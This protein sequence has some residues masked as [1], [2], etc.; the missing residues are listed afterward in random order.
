MGAD[1]K[2]RKGR[3]ALSNT[4]SRYEEYRRAAFDDGWADA[5]PDYVCPTT[6]LPDASK[7]IITFNKSP[8]IPFDRSINPY[9]GCEHGCVYCFARPSHTRLGLSAGLDF[10][11][12]LFFKENG[13]ELLRKELAHP[14][15]QAAELVLGANTD[16]Y[17]PVERKLGLTRRL[18]EVLAETKHPVSILTKSALVERDADILAEMAK[19]NLVRVFVS[20][21]TL[22]AKL[23]RALE[24]RA[25]SPARRLAILTSLTASGIP[26]GALIAPLIPVLTDP[27]LEQLLAAARTAGAL[28][29]DYVLLRLPSEIKTLFNEWLATH[30]PL[31]AAHVM[32]RVHDMRGGKA[33]DSEFGTRMTGTGLFAGIIAQ[34]FKLAHKKLQFPGM[35]ALNTSSSRWLKPRPCKGICSRKS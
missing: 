26:T 29:A 31:K 23:A 27:E 9:R 24:P 25:A 10:E 13:D 1:A 19:N 14:R 34:R 35:P 17:Q 15:Y 12:K 18:L 28:D 33:Y 11:T 7:S 5:P 6:L 22:D 21:T 16:A 4:N 30:A 2:A 8:D 20:I 32:A 3:G